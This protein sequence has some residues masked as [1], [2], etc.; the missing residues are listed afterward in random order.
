[1]MNVQT[2]IPVKSE[3]KSMGSKKKKKSDKKR[4]KGGGRR[5]ENTCQRGSGGPNVWRMNRASF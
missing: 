3:T 5:N 2:S 1:L 4:L